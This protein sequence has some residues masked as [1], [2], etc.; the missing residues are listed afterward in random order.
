MGLHTQPPTDYMAISKISNKLQP[1]PF[2]TLSII[3]KAKE[4]IT[5]QNQQNLA[6]PL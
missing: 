3:F 6:F 2:K 1:I 5:L 4:G